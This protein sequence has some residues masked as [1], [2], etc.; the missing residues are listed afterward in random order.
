M[1]KKHGIAVMLGV[2]VAVF[3]I[4]FCCVG[5]SLTASASDVSGKTLESAVVNVD[6]PA[7]AEPRLFTTLSLNIGVDNGE[8]W[9]AVK[10]EFTL[11]FATV[12]VY[13]QLYSSY[14]YQESYT[15][16]TFESQTYVE[17]LNIYETVRTASPTNG[18]QKYWMAR[19]R[20]RINSGD[21]K[22]KVSSLWLIDV[23]GNV[24]DQ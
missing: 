3:A 8:V 9:A 5:N 14:T 13:V 18:E 12:R 1:T 23:D 21:W 15:N 6:E 17:D 2:L 4:S 22:D 11:G 7:E 24:L 20:Y 19:A 10:N 16:M